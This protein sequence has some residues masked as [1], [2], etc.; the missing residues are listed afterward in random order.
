MYRHCQ[1]RFWRARGLDIYALF[2]NDAD[3]WAIRKARTLR[4]LVNGNFQPRPK[5]PLN[6]ADESKKATRLGGG[7]IG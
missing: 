4:G 7:S 6:R 1:G 2:N 5:S 3:V